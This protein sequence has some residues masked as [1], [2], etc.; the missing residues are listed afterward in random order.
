MTT[1]T[2]AKPAEINLEKNIFQVKENTLKH[3]NGT[4]IGPNCAL[5]YTILFTVDLEEII[6]E[7][8][9]LPPRMS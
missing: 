5:Q 2:L 1:E 3:L 9:D 8:I 4:A 7:D 6:L